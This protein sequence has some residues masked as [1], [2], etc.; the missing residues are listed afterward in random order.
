MTSVRYIGFFLLAGASLAYAN[1]PLPISSS[2]LGLDTLTTS[3]YSSG[4]SCV[5]VNG[6]ACGGE[7]T[8]T[9][10]TG[11]GNN[12]PVPIN[13][14]CVDSQEDFYFGQGGLAQ[15]VA[16]P[17]ITN[18]DPNVRY[19]GVT[20]SPGAAVWTNQTIS[21]PTGLPASSITLA[22]DAKTR[23]EMAAYLVSQFPGFDASVNGGNPESTAIEGAIWDIMSNNTAAENPFNYFP[24]LGTTGSPA[25]TDVDYWIYQASLASNY[26]S[27]ANNFA[28]LSWDAVNPSGLVPIGAGNAQ[29]FLVELSNTGGGGQNPTPEPTFYGALAIGMSGMALAVRRRK[30]LRS[31]GSDVGLFFRRP[32]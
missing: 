27:T 14:W 16:L 31:A 30:K 18:S 5:S 10:G 22:S 32:L 20:N 28:V 1:T 3:N 25:V 12:N 2:Y 9:L 17:Q 6:V 26:D 15:V 23:Y 7:F 29:T 21:L 13:F 8:G 24:A 4:S 11:V 19:S